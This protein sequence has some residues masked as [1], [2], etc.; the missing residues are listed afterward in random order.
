MQRR[1]PETRHAQ[2]AAL[3]RREYGNLVRRLQRLLQNREDAEEVSQLAFVKIVE[4]GGAFD[5]LTSERAFLFRIAQNLA[6]DHLRRRNLG[7]KIFKTTDPQEAESCGELRYPAEDAEEN[8]LARDLLRR[9]DSALD[10]LPPKCR[11]AFIM[12]KAQEQTFPE[13]AKTM[14]L[15]VSMIEKHMSRALSHVRNRVNLAAG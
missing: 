8:L 5:E 7:G 2:I 15:S 10:D 3:Y 4:V 12:G 14:G 6:I 13:I 1:S 9:V 11:T